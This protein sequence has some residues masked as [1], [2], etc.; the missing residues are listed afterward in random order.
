MKEIILLILTAL[1]LTRNVSN[2]YS[3]SITDNSIQTISTCSIEDS[4]N[5]FV[6]KGRIS[7]R[8]VINGQYDSFDYYTRSD[9]GYVKFGNR[10]YP[11]SRTQITINNILYFI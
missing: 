7:L 9:R 6:Y 4:N 5:G 11:L 2:P 3:F 1:G 8:R 10:Y